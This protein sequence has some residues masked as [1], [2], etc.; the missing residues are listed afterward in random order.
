MKSK[1]IAESGILVAATIV[2]L[3]TASILPISTLSVLTLA[4]CLIPISIIRTSVKNAILVY[5][6]SSLLSFF[7]LPIKMSIYYILFFGIYGVMKYFIERLNKLTLEIILKI[8]C[9]NTLLGFIY[10]IVT[11]FLGNF[12]IKFPIY[13]LWLI[14]Q[15]VFLIYD[16]A[17]TMIISIYLQ[18][19]HKQI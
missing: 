6:S 4:S 14:A 17:L 19:L 1:H 9:F 12:S 8:M 11:N 16:Y 10:F 5:L 3:Y 2:I 15:I 18:K 7:I 13:L